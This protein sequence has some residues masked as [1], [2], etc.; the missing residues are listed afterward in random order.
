MNLLENLDQIIVNLNLLINDVWKLVLF[1][2]SIQDNSFLVIIWS[3]VF[4]FVVLFISIYVLKI[5]LEGI[6]KFIFNPITFIFIILIFGLSVWTIIQIN[7]DYE[8]VATLEDSKNDLSTTPN[9]KIEK[10]DPLTNNLEDDQKLSNA[11][12]QIEKLKEEIKKQSQV[13][14]ELKSN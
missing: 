9:V 5:I 7:N 2:T 11:L 13:I 10:I 14:Q 6:F 4:Y 8:F 3:M 12:I 1:E